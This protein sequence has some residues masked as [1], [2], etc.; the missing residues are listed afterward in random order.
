VKN[1]APGRFFHA[2]NPFGYVIACFSIRQCREEL[3]NRLSFVCR[4]AAFVPFRDMHMI[5]NV[6]QLF[7][8]ISPGTGSPHSRMP[9]IPIAGFPVIRR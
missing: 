3:S 6:S 4:R 9:A 8:S 1:A 5:A 7:F 2:V